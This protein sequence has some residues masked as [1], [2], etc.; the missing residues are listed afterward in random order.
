[1]H[2]CV[3][4]HVRACECVHV[5][6]GICMCPSPCPATRVITFAHVHT[7]AK[8]SIRAKDYPFQTQLFN[9]QLHMP[10]QNFVDKTETLV[11]LTIWSFVLSCSIL[12]EAWDPFQQWD[13]LFFYHGYMDL[14]I[15]CVQPQNK[16]KQLL[17]QIRV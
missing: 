8:A 5:H 15:A 7:H 2:L 4:V 17:V 14:G 16:K 3:H 13:T 9:I 10:N 6:I 11:I 1:M 12:N